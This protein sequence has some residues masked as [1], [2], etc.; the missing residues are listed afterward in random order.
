MV[1]D[2]D[3]YVI[4]FNVRMCD[5][6]TQVI[7][8]LLKSSLFELLWYATDGKLKQT[9]VVTSSMTSVTVVMAANGY[10]GKYKKGMRIEGLDTV[11]KGA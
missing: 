6:E 4:E 11:N 2:G 10:P 5:S 9:K 7:L 3:P 1:V 8:P